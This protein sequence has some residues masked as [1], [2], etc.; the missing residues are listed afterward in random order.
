[1]F[2]LEDFSSNIY[3]GISS[4]YAVSSAVCSIR[5]RRRPADGARRTRGGNS[6]ITFC[7]FAGTHTRAHHRMRSHT[8]AHRL[9][10]YRRISNFNVRFASTKQLGSLFLVFPFPPSPH[11]P[12]TLH[13]SP[14]VRRKRGTSCHPALRR[15][16]ANVQF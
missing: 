11:C 2:E 13:C 10:L 9:T 1:M 12:Q 14:Y 4:K 3:E 16:G 5:E 7:T 8:H 6:L 15:D